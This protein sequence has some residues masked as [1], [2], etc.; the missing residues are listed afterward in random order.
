MSDPRLFGERVKDCILQAV[1]GKFLGEGCYRKVYALDDARVLKVEEQGRSFSNVHEWTIWNDVQGTKWERWFAPCLDM[2]AFGTALI[3][4]RTTPLT[5][6]Q[7]CA[8][9][10][11]PDFLSD[12]KPDNFG[13]LK[14]RV[15]C[16]DYGNHGCFRRAFTKGRLVERKK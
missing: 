11:I 8:F 5:D 13:M 1:I 6:R 9:K 16:H 15:V 3:Q 2:D 7:W 10:Q 4:A 12:L 14:G